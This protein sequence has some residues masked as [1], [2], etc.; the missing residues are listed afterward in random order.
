MHQLIPTRATILCA[1]AL[2]SGAFLT[3]SLQTP[4]RAQDYV[5]TA[6]LSRREVVGSWHSA[7][8]N[9]YT[10]RGNGTYTFVTGN[11]AS[12]N[13]SHSG[14]WKLGNSGRLLRLHA[15][16]RIVLEGRKRRTLKA[17]KNFAFEIGTQDPQAGFLL[18]SEEFRPANERF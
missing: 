4:V 17:N 15:T 14:T 7:R 5:D 10:F 8:N 9:K 12:G 6:S 11:K 3:P 2:M 13:V 1:F 18:G 16:R